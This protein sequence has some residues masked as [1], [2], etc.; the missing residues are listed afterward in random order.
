VN[1]RERERLKREHAKRES[2]AR[3]ESLDR[4][5]KIKVLLGDLEK[6]LKKSPDVV[7]LA[8]D[9]RKRIK[10]LLE[11]LKILF[12]DLTDEFKE[13]PDAV[14]E[15]VKA[16]LGK[17]LVTDDLGKTRQELVRL[18]QCQIEYLRP[19]CQV[20]QGIREHFP[21]EWKKLI[22]KVIEDAS[23]L[24]AAQLTPKQ[25]H[26]AKRRRRFAAGDIGLIESEF[27]EAWWQNQPPPSSALLPQPTCLDEILAGGS[28][29]TERLK[30]LFGMQ[31]NRFG[32]LPTKGLHNHRT[33]FTIM[34]KLL[35]EKPSERKTAGRPLRT[36]LKPDVRARVLIGIEVR[37]SSLS[38]SVPEQIKAEFLSLVHRHLPDSAKK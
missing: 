2:E 19:F 17:M 20:V 3:E 37:I 8:K 4:Q 18:Q 7:K 33:V 9:Q 34:D 36:W 5:E 27:G 10:L 22:V 16:E 14:K 32:K 25:K 21:D 12:E 38:M 23:A 29:N 13:S 30:E 15:L 1:K 11:D 31:R 6:K 28:V 26:E 24:L 35:S